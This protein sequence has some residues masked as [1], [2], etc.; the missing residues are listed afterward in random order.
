MKLH[1]LITQE[2]Y[3]RGAKAAATDIRSFNTKN[4]LHALV[5][6]AFDPSRKGVVLKRSQVIR[7][8]ST[9]EITGVVDLARSVAQDDADEL[10]GYQAALTGWLD[11]ALRTGQITLVDKTAE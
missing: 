11:D 9:V 10:V 8:P 6:R 4:G 2:A 3:D 7:D 5:R 1:D